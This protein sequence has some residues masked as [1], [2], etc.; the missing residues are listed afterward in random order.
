MPT[1]WDEFLEVSQAI[2][3]AGHIPMLMCGA[4]PW[5]VS[6]P[7]VGLVSQNVF[8]DDP[9]PANLLRFGVEYR[10]TFRPNQ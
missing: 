10:I 8:G 7:A 5:C 6:F 1:T 9:D 4:E 2:K 3:D